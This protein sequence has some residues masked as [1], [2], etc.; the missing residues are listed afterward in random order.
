MSQQ[1]GRFSHPKVRPTAPENAARLIEM[2]EVIEALRAPEGCPWDR[3]Q[4][5]RTLRPYL[6]EETYELLEAI[7]SADDEEISEELGDVLLQ[8]FMHHA[9]A[10][11]EGRFSI[12]DVAHHATAKMINRHPHVFG[13][14]EA[15]TAEQVLTNW[16]GLKQTEARKRGRVSALEGAPRT[17]P[18]LAWALSLQKRAAR[19]GFDWPDQEGVLDKVAEEARELA[20]ETTRERQEEELGDLL[21]TLV[22]LAR[23]LKINPEDALRQS[24]GRFYRRFESMEAA[25]RDRG[26]DVREMSA[27]ELDALWDGAKTSGS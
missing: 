17:L 9:I 6:L 27:E 26:S 11:E 25:A 14:V 10:Q 8:V 24:S 7:D 4:T 18:A 1:E 13:D 19:V 16:E 5:H 20:A 22:N 15:R 23:R 12:G 21:F 3:E 2:L